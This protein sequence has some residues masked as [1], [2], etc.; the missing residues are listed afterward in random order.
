M[1]RPGGR[2]AQRTSTEHSA[3][4]EAIHHLEAALRAP[5]PGRSQAWGESVRKHLKALHESLLEHI[6]SAEGPGGLYEELEEEAPETAQRIGYLRETNR[7]LLD[8]S[9]L[10]LREVDRVASGEGQAFMAVR[11]NAAALLNELRAQQSREVD[12][13]YEVFERDIGVLD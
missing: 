10:L 5:A 2:S 11:S 9:E 3:L 7:N 4:V 6:R 12:L 13:I 1:D 8:R